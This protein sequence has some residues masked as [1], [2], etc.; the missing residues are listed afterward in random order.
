ME[1][2]KRF[3]V[4]E[5][6]PAE[7]LAKKPEFKGKTL[8]DVLY[9]N[10]KVNKFQTAD[11]TKVNAKYIPGYSN[12][13]SPRPLASTC[14]RASSRSTPS[15][16]VATGTISPLRRL[17]R[18][19]GLPLARGGWQGDADGASAR[20][21]DPYVKKGEGVKFYGHKDG[22]AVVFALPYQPAA[23]APDKDFDLW[24]CTGRVLEGTGTPA[25]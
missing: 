1:F 18:A 6:W 8:F 12:T 15:L 17:S 20:G 4:E 10:G 16:A 23:E 24:L 25:P 2:S 13:T 11:L 9:K 22:R 21:Y 19:R 5:V 7:L 14:R 3:R